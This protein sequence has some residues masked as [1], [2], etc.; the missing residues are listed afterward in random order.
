MV[1]QPLKLYVDDLSTTLKSAV[2]TVQTELGL[3]SVNIGDWTSL[4][5]PDNYATTLPMVF[6]SFLNTAE[7]ELRMNR[8]R[9]VYNFRVR[10]FRA[11]LDADLGTSAKIVNQA[12]TRIWQ[13]LQTSNDPT[14]PTIP[15]YFGTA[16]DGF[17]WEKVQ[18][19]GPNL[20]NEDNAHLNYLEYRVN[21]AW[22]DLAI[23]G[24]STPYETAD[25][26]PEPD[27]LP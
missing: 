5:S 23:T 6:V 12:A 9:V 18:V 25:P 21:C 26:P 22:I 2:E 16:I 14:K 7:P 4:P 17:V 19:R 20:V 24:T 3:V 11:Q 15:A 27:P 1:N 10:Y 13:A 8:M